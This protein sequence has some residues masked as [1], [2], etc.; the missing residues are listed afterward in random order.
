MPEPGR[1]E[2]RREKHPR[3]ARESGNI[4]RNSSQNPLS[5]SQAGAGRAAG[6][7]G[8]VGS[9]I[10]GRH[11]K[12][13]DISTALGAWEGPG[14]ARRPLQPQDR[15]PE[16]RGCF[17]G[18]SAFPGVA[19]SRSRS[20]GWGQRDPSGPGWARGAPS[21]RAIGA[22]SFAVPRPELPGGKQSEFPVFRPAGSCPRLRD[23]PQVSPVSPGGAGWA[24]WLR[25]EAHPAGI[26]GWIRGFQP[27][28]AAG[29]PQGPRKS[30]MLPPGRINWQE[31]GI[32]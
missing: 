30:W 25:P 3:P 9:Q 32:H 14:G 18:I 11:P 26:P 17:P 20:R 2:R 31:F 7:S 28:P 6:S 29:A 27:A 22:L 5:E 4:R 21:P 19:R 10:Q 13:W 8:G 12:S 23:P 16:L 24:P 15:D 1:G